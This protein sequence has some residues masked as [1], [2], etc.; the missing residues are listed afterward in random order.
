MYKSNI[1]GTVSRDRRVPFCGSSAGR[2]KIT[3]SIAY[4]FPLRLDLSS[5]NEIWHL[6][7]ITYKVSFQ[8]LGSRFVRCDCPRN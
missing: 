7:V 8:P 3:E 4:A 1:N 2:Q 5:V 6:S